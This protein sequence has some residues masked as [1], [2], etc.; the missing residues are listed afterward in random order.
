MEQPHQILLESCHHAHNK[1]LLVALPE[2]NPSHRHPALQLRSKRY[3]TRSQG[4][5]EVPAGKTS[6]GGLQ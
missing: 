6:K 4:T 3:R 1:I 2:Q 5:Q